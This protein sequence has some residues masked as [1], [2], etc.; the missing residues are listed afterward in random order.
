MQWILYLIKPKEQP[1]HNL[2]C[3]NEKPND[4]QGQKWGSVYYVWDSATA[5]ECKGRTKL[6][7]LGTA[8]KKKALKSYRWRSDL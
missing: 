5:P 2:T 6:Q 3:C 4:R 1:A 7:A 8:D